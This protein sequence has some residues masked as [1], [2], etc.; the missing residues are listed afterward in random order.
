MNQKKAVRV[1]AVLMAVIMLISLVVSV[2]PTF[3]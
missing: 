3:A 2:I 1:I